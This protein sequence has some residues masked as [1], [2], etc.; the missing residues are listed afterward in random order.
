M[1][2]C[3]ELQ[4]E[5]C[6]LLDISFSIV[7]EMAKKSNS[8]KLFPRVV[9]CHLSRTVKVYCFLCL[10]SPTICRP[11]YPRQKGGC[12]S[13]IWG[14]DFALETP[15]MSYRENVQLFTKNSILMLGKL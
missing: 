4:L 2:T 13:V 7:F 6:W 12:M 14:P 1:L 5:L 11:N 3:K 8:C 9:G 15:D 10:F